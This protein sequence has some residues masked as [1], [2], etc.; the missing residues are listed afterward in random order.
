MFQGKTSQTERQWKSL[1]LC[2]M[3]PRGHPVIVDGLALPNTS[4]DFQNDS[5]HPKTPPSVYNTP[6]KGVKRCFAL[7]KS[8]NSYQIS[9]HLTLFSLL[10]AQRKLNATKPEIFGN[11]LNNANNITWKHSAHPV[12]KLARIAANASTELS[13]KLVSLWCSPAGRH[14]RR[15][16]VEWHNKWIREE[17]FPWFVVWTV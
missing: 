12:S 17:W 15:A 1:L 16:N 3:I 2:T 8:Q 6:V 9:E 14:A 4:G 11:N 10:T 7:L 13:W 5:S